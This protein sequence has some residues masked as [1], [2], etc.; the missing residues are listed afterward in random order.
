MLL[1]F[2]RVRIKLL[3]MVITEVYINHS[4]RLVHTYKD[5]CF[6]MRGACAMLYVV[7]NTVGLMISLDRHFHVSDS[8]LGTIHVVS[9]CT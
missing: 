4:S 5:L 3:V 8:I 9:M 1:H 6:A 2:K 7:A